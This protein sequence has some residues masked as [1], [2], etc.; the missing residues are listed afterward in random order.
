MTYRF[1]RAF[2]EVLRET[3]AVI[4]DREAHGVPGGFAADH[5]S[6]PGRFGKRILRVLEQIV[7]DL[8]QLRAVSDDARQ[9]I[10]E[11]ELDARANRFVKREDLAHERVQI[12]LVH[13]RL[14]R[15]R[16]LAEG[17][18]HPFQRRH[19][20][21]DRA[22]RTREHLGVGLGQLGRELQLHA[23]GGKLNRRERVLDFVREP[24]RDLT[25]GLVAL[26]LQKMR[27]VVEYHDKRGIGALRKAR[28]AQQQDLCAVP[29]VALDLLLPL[30]AAPRAERVA[31]RLRHGAQRR[32]ERVPRAELALDERRTL[33][34][35]DLVGAAV[36]RSELKVLVEREHTCRKIVENALELDFGVGELR[37]LVLGLRARVGELHGHAVERTREHS[38][39]VA[40]RIGRA[41]A[42]VALRDGAGAFDQHVE[43]GG[44]AF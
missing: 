17:I 10:G 30:V 6:G 25:P 12:E 44:Q 28:A 14:G 37:F 24:P 41:L 5:D 13:D 1:E 27:H 21:D 32:I 3:R 38:E 2:H 42:E 20:I 15:S 23:L 26:R 22:R 39:L 29:R 34:P 16:I 19:L 8:A 18:D 43:R 35:Q 7:H 4:G 40:A 31:N 11:L 9:I 36:R 33:D